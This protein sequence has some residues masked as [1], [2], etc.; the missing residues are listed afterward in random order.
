MLMKIFSELKKNLKN[1]FSPLRS[2]KIALLGDTSTQLLTQA[3][4]GTGF[5][6]GFDLMIWE[7]DFNQIELQVFDP[8]SPLYAFA[9]EVVI[10]FHSSHQLLA[11]YNKLSPAEYDSLA[12][13]R[14]T[15]ISDLHTALNTGL[16][17]KII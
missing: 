9:P 10:I 4:R 11:K 17:A 1:D 12:Q 2:V 16:N 5:D 8:K 6:M 3:L 14:L 13:N 15:L 7:A